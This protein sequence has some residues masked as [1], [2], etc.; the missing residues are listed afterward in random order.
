MTIFLQKD[1]LAACC[2]VGY[3][4]GLFYVT[5]VLTLLRFRFH[6]VKNCLGRANYAGDGGLLRRDNPHPGS[7]IL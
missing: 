5:P 7:R 1:I 6:I 3:G 2:V 4:L